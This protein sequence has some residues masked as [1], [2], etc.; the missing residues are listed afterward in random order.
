MSSASPYVVKRD[1]IKHDP[2]L[3][4]RLL[5]EL[6]IE[7]TERC[8]N[9]CIHCY[10][11]LAADDRQARLRELGTEEWQDILHQAADAGAMMVTLTGGEPLLREDFADIYLYAR[12]LGLKIQLNTNARLITPEIG[13]LFVRMP[14]GQRIE[15]TVYGMNERSY[16][17]ATRVPGSYGEFW[18]GIEVLLQ[19]HIP[20]GVRM[21]VLPPNEGEVEPFEAW[22]QTIPG[23]NGGLPGYVMSLQLRTRRDSQIRNRQIVGLRL[24]A[25]AQVKLLTRHAA[26]YRRH[27]ARFLAKF[28]YARGDRLFTC[29]A[30]KGGCVDAY[31]FLQPCMNL[32][33]PALVH[34]LKKESLRSAHPRMFPS[35]RQLRA[36]NPEYLSRCARCFLADMCGQCP[37]WSWAEHGTLDTP[38]DYLCQAAHAQARYLGLLAEEEM[39]WQVSDWSDRIAHL[40]RR[41]GVHV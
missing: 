21:A 37:G 39:A 26:G 4:K 6:D 27:M 14:P 41:T 5:S 8:N 9:N 35:L 30:G 24:P 7:L 1:R 31:G 22:A 18:R 11:N 12:R 40:V 19:R 23:M 38:V 16:E 20:F 17:A 3:G 28:G 33:H 36:S 32:R 10:I 15:V 13:E 29:G 25:E 34:D 2:L